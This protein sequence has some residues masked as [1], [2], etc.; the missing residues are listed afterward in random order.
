MN[1]QFKVFMIIHL[2]IICSG[3]VTLQFN[4]AIQELFCDNY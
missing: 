3:V 2:L 4:R 1:I